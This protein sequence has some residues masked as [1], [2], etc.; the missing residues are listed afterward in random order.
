M[1]VQELVADRCGDEYDVVRR[2][3]RFTR[4]LR[5]LEKGPLYTREFLGII[6]DWGDSFELLK[7][8]SRLGLIQRY[9]DY[10]R[11][12]HRRRCVYN[13]VTEK[14]REF[15]SL[16]DRLMKLISDSPV[17]NRKCYSF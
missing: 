16:I 1:T 6:S 2:I 3:Y 11:D 8:M 15:L 17:D 9:T 4:A 10:C 7:E 12:S 5:I 13:R 14:G